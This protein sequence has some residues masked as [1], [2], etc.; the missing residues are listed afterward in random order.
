MMN[1]FN[2]IA[3]AEIA[4]IYCYSGKKTILQV[5]KTKTENTPKIMSKISVR[6]GKGEITV[7]KSSQLVGVKTTGKEDIK[8][9]SFVKDEMIPS[10]GGFNIVTLEHDQQSVDDKLDEVRQREDVAVG[11]HVYY[12]EGSNKPMVPTGEIFIVF[13]DGVAEE[14]QTV[15]LEEFA[16]KLEERRDDATIVVSVTDQSPNPLKVASA[17]QKIS[18]IKLAE[19]DLDMP[20]DEYFSEPRDELVPHEWHL[21]NS[22]FVVDV[23]FRLRKGADAKV[24]DAWRRLGSTGAT[25]INVAIIDNG[26]DLSHPDLKDKVVKPYNVWDRNNRIPQGNP[27]Y[28]HGTPCASVAVASSNNQGIVGAAPNARFMPVHGTSFSVRDTEE[29]FN[30]C[31]NNGADVISCSWGTTDSNF[32]LSP[33]KEQVMA[34]AAREGRNGKGC[35]ICFAAGNE[36]LNYLNFYATH[37]DVIAVGASTSQDTHASYSN[38]GRELSVVAPSN[39]DWPIIAARASWDQGLSWESGDFKY[40]RDGRSRGANYKHFGGTSSSTPLVAGICALIL[41]ANP[42]L[43]AKEVKDILQKTA[44]KIGS[45][46]E[47]VN[48]H[49]VKYGYGRV[50]ADKAVAEALRRADKPAPVIE[51]AEQVSGGQ[52]L[53]RF[54]VKRQNPSGWGV[55]IGAF[56]D[57]GNVLIQ[58]EKLQRVFGQPVIVNIN[59]LNGKT[60]Y[61]VVVGHT[62]DRAGVNDLLKSIQ[63]GGYPGAFPRNL[64]DLG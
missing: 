56:Y 44:D 9:K 43:T 51:V 59:E 41:S 20:L 55:Q 35:V 16:L 3:P 48:G 2:A 49:S 4:F 29:M 12:A 14:E 21:E 17:L 7:K 37:P 42:D 27:Q 34:K 8:D 64:A 36:D 52:G 40:W 25:G 39:G 46:A 32:T 62:S 15:V 28:T 58:T 13:E 26:F 57:Y 60:V 6:S 5:S 30:Y 1:I 50:N 45:P 10:L 24:I 33:L 53:F 31:I 38:R 18:L 22:G 61:K 19:P 47:Y 54:D 63:S 23:N 11:T